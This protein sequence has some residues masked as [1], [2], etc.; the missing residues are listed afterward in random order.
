MV[1][2]EQSQALR[3]AFHEKHFVLRF[4]GFVEMR[5][6][7]LSIEDLRQAGRESE[8]LEEYPD[9]PE[10]HTKLLLGKL[11]DRPIHLVINVQEFH[12][13]PTDP[14]AIVTVYE[15]ESPFWRDERTRGKA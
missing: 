13:D 14:V 2:S 5:T 15:P 4:H 6:E 10:G 11:A 3:W 9:R 12:D 8:I 1:E 7:G